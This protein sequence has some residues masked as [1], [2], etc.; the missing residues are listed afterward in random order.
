MDTDYK[1][2]KD[3]SKRQVHDLSYC[4]NH[5]MRCFPEHTIR[6]GVIM[7]LLFY[8]FFHGEVNDLHFIVM[9]LSSFFLPYFNSL[10][11]S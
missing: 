7:P 3:S 11:H 1:T 8:F 2:G 10:L 6:V 5:F 9:S 4:S